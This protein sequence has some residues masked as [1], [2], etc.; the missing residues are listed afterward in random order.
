MF[1]TNR[2][3]KNQT[4]AAKDSWLSGSTAKSSSNGVA[5][6][7]KWST[8]LVPSGSKSVTAFEPSAKLVPYGKAAQTSGSGKHTSTSQSSSASSSSSWGERT[9]AQQS[10]SFSNG[11]TSKTFASSL[12][13]SYQS[14][15]TN[16]SSSSTSSTRPE[17]TIPSSINKNVMDKA[18]N[19]LTYKSPD[20]IG[21]TGHTGIAAS[22]Y[23]INKNASAVAYKPV[24][25][26]TPG[27][28]SS[29]VVGTGALATA[30]VLYPALSGGPDTTSPPTLSIAKLNNEVPK[31]MPS[32]KEKSK[33]FLTQQDQSSLSSSS[34]GLKPS[35]NKPTISEPHKTPTT[36]SPINS[37]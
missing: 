21:L 30:A 33:P 3:N 15:S 31:P 25:S 19:L 14:H 36:P 18:T 6:K 5:P 9:I 16:A 4:S 32:I 13:S 29:A 22:K 37:R 35:L 7:S 1:S 17:F 10:S 26:R 20:R 24:Y 8:S 2:N 34:R 11:S 28:Y 27:G 23:L 12:S